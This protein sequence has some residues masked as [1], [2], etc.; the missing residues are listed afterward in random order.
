M[1]RRKEVLPLS[2]TN[3]A[4]CKGGRRR[5]EGDNLRTD[6]QT[7]TA[8]VQCEKEEED[9][10]AY[11]YANVC[12]CGREWEIKMII[13]MMLMLM[14]MMFCRGSGVE[15]CLSLLLRMTKWT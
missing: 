5:G 11:A 3:N 6:R 14:M 10:N 7:L 1:R 15:V 13:M 4:T 2:N 8:D 9:A 12:V